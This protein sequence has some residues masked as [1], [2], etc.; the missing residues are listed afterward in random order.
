MVLATATV[1]MFATPRLGPRTSAST[2]K[3][4]TFERRAFAVL[5]ELLVR[6]KLPS[7]RLLE[8]GVFAFHLYLSDDGAVKGRVRSSAARAGPQSFR[9]H[10]FDQLLGVH[11]HFGIGEHLRG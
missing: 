7:L 1:A 9:A 4:P 8:P 11:R 5:I 2:K 10:R 3:R 6:G